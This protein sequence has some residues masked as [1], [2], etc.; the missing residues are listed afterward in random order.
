M[1]AIDAMIVIND[2]LKIL[3]VTAIDAIIVINDTLKMMTMTAIDALKMLKIMIALTIVNS[4][5]KKSRSTSC[6]RIAD[7]IASIGTSRQTRLR[8]SCEASPKPFSS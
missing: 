8:T 5:R 1:T 4:R 6:R 3:K 7:P 2:A